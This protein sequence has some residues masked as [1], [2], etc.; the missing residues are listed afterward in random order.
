MA[1]ATL[2]KLG[3][4]TVVALPPVYL[5]TFGCKAGDKVEITCQPDKM[6]IKVQK[7]RLSLKERLEMYK[8]A[9]PHRTREEEMEEA[10][11]DNLK[12]VGKELI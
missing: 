1:I 8:K 6:E 2:R 11:W 5:E 3:G 9:L 7:K 10:A 4:S 12:P